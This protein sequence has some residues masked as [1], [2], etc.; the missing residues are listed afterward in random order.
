[1]NC[2]K[3]SRRLFVRSLKLKN[4]QC[5]ITHFLMY[6]NLLSKFIV[7]YLLSTARTLFIAETLDLARYQRN[8]QDATNNVEN[9]NHFKSKLQCFIERA[10]NKEATGL[11]NAIEV[12]AHLV[13]S[14]I[15]DIKLIKNTLY[16]YG[17]LK[18]VTDEA[19]RSIGNLV[20]KAIYSIDRP[21][22]AFEVTN[23]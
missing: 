9:P 1:M 12:L 2:L 8:R 16:A 7:L 18:V 14:D 21:D 10:H 22:E 6:K 11:K 4:V 20:M 3:L 5:E 15:D 17:S 13:Q 19:K 23:T